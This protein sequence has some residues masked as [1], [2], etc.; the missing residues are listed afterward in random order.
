MKNKDCFFK[1]ENIS[2]ELVFDMFYV[3][4]L[5]KNKKIY[6][7]SYEILLSF[8][9]EQNKN[10]NNKE[11]LTRMIKNIWGKKITDT[12]LVFLNELVNNYEGGTCYISEINKIGEIVEKCLSYLKEQF[13]DSDKILIL[14]DPHGKNMFFHLTGKTL[15]EYFNEITENIDFI[16]YCYL[17]VE[18]K[19]KTKSIIEGAKYYK[20]LYEII[21]NTNIC[22]SKFIESPQ[23][24]LS[25]IIPK[26]IIITNNNNNIYNYEIEGIIGCGSYGCVVK[27][28]N[29]NENNSVCLKIY[30]SNKCGKYDKITL[31]KMNNSEEL[32]DIIIDSLYLD[33]YI[34]SMENNMLNTKNTD[35]NKKRELSFLLM[36]CGNPID[37]N[38]IDN[39]KN[40]IKHNIS[41]IQRTIEKTIKLLDKGIYFTDLKKCNILLY[42]NDVRFIDLD[43][44]YFFEKDNRIIFSYKD[45]ILHLIPV[46]NKKIIINSHNIIN[47]EK[48][49]V[50]KIVIM[51]LELFGYDTI[52]MEKCNFEMTWFDFIEKYFINY[53][54]QENLSILKDMFIPQIEKISNI[55][56]VNQAFTEIIANVT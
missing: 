38:F 11:I 36:K 49:M 53:C 55:R 47:L 5:L 35:C 26:K 19:I 56:K 18:S 8:F 16:N 15:F 54:S 20:N 4:D 39:N 21:N 13:L 14:N 30:L 6:R 37:K 24:Y 52:K 50:F 3:Y 31:D 42:E 51:V 17:I 32:D 29:N 1:N 40:N 25:Y 28:N 45:L 12:F 9:Y 41:I 48:I 27:Y 33:E 44:F 34:L 43:S 46:I 7:Y 10:D 2:K 23:I 22:Y